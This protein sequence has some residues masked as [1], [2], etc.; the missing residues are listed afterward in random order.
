MLVLDS[1]H[2][3]ELSYRSPLG[4]RL[5]ARLLEAGADAVTTVVCAEESLRGWLAR[6]AGAR[7]VNEQVKGYGSFA[8]QIDFLAKFTMLPWDEGAAERF[9]SLRGQAVRIGTMDL[10]IACIT[11][12]HDALLLT[13]NA[14][15]FSK[16]PGLRFENWLD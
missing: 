11:L 10:K 3:Q 12:E 16:V 6:I 7:N 1:N 5:E 2:L 4:V 15:D 13:R 14:V 8:R 9:Q